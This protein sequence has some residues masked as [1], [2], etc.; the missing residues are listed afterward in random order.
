MSAIDFE[1]FVERLTTAAGEA[2]LPFFRTAVGI[3]NKGKGG[4][5]PVT[6]ADRAGEAAIRQIIKANFPNHGV[7][8]EE[9]GS[10]NDEAE[11]TWIIDPIDGTRSFITGLP[12]WGTLIG[13]LRKGTPVYGVM[14]QP[15]I[16]ERFVGDGASACC[17]GPHGERILTTRACESLSEAVLCTTSPRLFSAQEIKAFETLEAQVQL[18]RFGGDCY[19]YCMLAA[20]HVDLVVEAGLA[21]YDILPLIPIV[22]GAGGIVTAWDGGP[23]TQGGRVI[24]AGDK[25]LHA[26]AVEFLQAKIG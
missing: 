5:D 22:E 21:P 23:A 8:G 6:A 19:N 12:A 7:I 16:K 10:E 3:E 14:S 24:A 1:S 4:F 9:F 25:G 18:T 2:V 17:K 15:F 11:Y 13:L 20:G 26:K